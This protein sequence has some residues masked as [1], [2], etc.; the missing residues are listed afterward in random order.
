MAN[1]SFIKNPIELIEKT[2]ST[3]QS[4][5]FRTQS[6][7]RASDYFQN[8]KVRRQFIIGTFVNATK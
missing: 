6:S 5:L 2:L 7:I 3:P 4:A 8:C 1:D